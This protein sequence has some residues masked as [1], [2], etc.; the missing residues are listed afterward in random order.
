VI[1]EKAVDDLR[2]HRAERLAQAQHAQVKR[3]LGAAEAALAA[4][5][6]V[7]AATALRIASSMTPDDPELGERLRLAE[8]R[9][10]SEQADSYL[11]QAEY[12][13]RHGKFAEAARAYERAS[14]GKSSPRVSERIAYCLLESNGDSRKA[15][16]NARRAVAST[17]DNAGYRLTLG[18]AYLLA[19]MRQSALGELERAQ[20]L[21]PGDD[22]IKDWIRRIKR[23]EV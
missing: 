9:A 8:A 15:L 11:A 5:N 4:G 7:S 10:A 12:E 19:G 21:A 1:R 20:L 16:E 6:A 22:K 13:E 17:A 23:H 18:R 14:L 3:Y 2:R